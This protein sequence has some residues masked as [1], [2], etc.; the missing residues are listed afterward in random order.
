MTIRM[1]PNVTTNCSSPLIVDEGDDVICECKCKDGNP[2][3]KCTWYGND[4]KIVKEGLKLN[5]LLTRRNV[6][7]QDSGK[8][9]CVGLSHTA[10]NETSINV[11]VKFKPKNTRIEFSMNPAVINGSVNVTC[12]SDGFPGLNYAFTHNNTDLNITG[13]VYVIHKVAWKDAGTYK[14]TAN[15][16]LGNDSDSKI[17]TVVPELKSSSAI[18]A[19]STIMPSPT[20]MPSLKTPV[21]TN[22]TTSSSTPKGNG[23]NDNGSKGSNIPAIAAGAAAGGA[24]LA[25]MAALYYKSKKGGNKSNVNPNGSRVIS[26][27]GMEAIDGNAYDTPD[28]SEGSQKTEKPAADSHVYAAVDKENRKGN[29]LYLS[30]DSEALKRPSQKKPAESLPKNVPTE[31][32][33]IDFM[34]TAKTPN[35]DSV[36]T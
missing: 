16:T 11:K 36:S 18:M 25:G 3:A 22:T 13:N 32:A 26:N 8:Y 24:A 19:S 7:E 1:K 30:L 21:P 2:P 10:R 28:K 34:K 33:S 12:A 35:D 27:H 6:S 20:V 17:L 5:A 14:C 9:K 29:T 15:N 23:T 31:Y 4:G